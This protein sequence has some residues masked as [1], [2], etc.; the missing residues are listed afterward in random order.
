MCAVHAGATYA[1]G[2]V[3]N[4]KDP[5]AGSILLRFLRNTSMEMIQVMHVDACACMR[6]CVRAH[7]RVRAR[8]CV[9]KCDIMT[10]V[11][12]FFPISWLTIGTLLG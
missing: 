5:Q 7:A 12:Y 1:G 9:C 2:A 10:L 4:E 3:V 6:T 11:L 8:M